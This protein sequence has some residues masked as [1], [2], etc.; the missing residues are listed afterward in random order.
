MD[1][2][3]NMLRIAA[4]DWLWYSLVSAAIMLIANCTQNGGE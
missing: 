1:G 3:R 2:G 4:N